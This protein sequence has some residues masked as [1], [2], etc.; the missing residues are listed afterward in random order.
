MATARF[1]VVVGLLLL[2]HKVLHVLREEAL[3]LAHGVGT[4]IDVLWIMRQA[5]VLRSVQK[6]LGR[7]GV[8]RGA[9]HLFYRERA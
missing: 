1:R 7:V 5:H 8:V 2:A 4:G 6:P 3:L 9:S